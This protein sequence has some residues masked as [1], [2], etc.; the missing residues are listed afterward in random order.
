LSSGSFLTRGSFS[1]DAR[2]P[3]RLT[4][5]GGGCTRAGWGAIPFARRMSG[6]TRVR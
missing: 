1:L 2:T 6:G 3:A 5:A 4:L